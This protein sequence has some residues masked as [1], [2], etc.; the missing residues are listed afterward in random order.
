MRR[1]N[2]SVTIKEVEKI[3]RLA[4]IVLDEQEKEEL[5]G[6][7]NEILAYIDKLNELDTE[8]VEPMS[9]PLDLKNV[10]RSDEPK[11]SLPQNKALENAPSK[12][13]KFFKVP[14]VITR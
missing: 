10:F 1:H 7:M 14:K 2:L 8:D 9:H 3:A 12:T 13:D 11:E 6:Q 5:T 4:R